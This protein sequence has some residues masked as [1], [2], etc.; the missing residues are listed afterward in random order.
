MDSLI[1]SSNFSTESLESITSPLVSS[2]ASIIQANVHSLLMSDDALE[3]LDLIFDI[4]D[5]AYAL[6]VLSEI[7]VNGF[8]LPDIQIVSEDIMAGALGGYAAE[9][10]NIYLSSALLSGDRIAGLI[11][12][13][14]EEVGHHLDTLLNGAYDSP[15]DEGELFRHHLWNDALSTSELSAIQRQDDHAQILVGGQSIQIEQNNSLGNAT[16]LG[17]LGRSVLRQGAIG[18]SDRNDYYRFS[19]TQSTAINLSLSNLSADADVQLLDSTGTVI[20]S[21][22]QG[23][24][25]EESILRRLAA[26][27]YF[28]RVYPFGNATTNYNL[29]ISVDGAGDSLTAAR[30]L[31]VFSGEGEFTDRIGD[32]DGND[33]Y[34]FTISQNSDFSLALDQLDADADV[35]LLNS[36]GQVITS[37]RRG[38]SNAESIR[39]TLAP[40][41][42]YARVYPFGT[43]ATDYR[44]QL[45]VDGAGNSLATAQNL[46]SISTLTTLNDF[47][48]QSDTND[49]YRF[50]LAQSRD[51]NLSL[52]NLAADADLQLLNSA[53]QVLASSVRSGSSSESISRSLAAGR[54]Y[55]RVY[56]FG[57]TTNT[58]YR[59]QLN[60]DG[61][62]NSLATARAVGQL[63]AGTT[64]FN[65]SVD[66]SD[67]NDFYRFSL[68][69][70][71]DLGVDLTGLS[72]DADLQFLDSAGAVITSSRRSGSSSEQLRLSL[73]AGTYYTRVYPFNGATTDYNLQF[74][75][76]QAGNSLTAA[77]NL[78]VLSGTQTFS[79][80][81][82]S[83]DQNDYYRFELSNSSNF[84]LSLN[85]LSEDADVQ[86]LNSAGQVITSSR[87]SN[88]N[89]ESIERFLNSGTYYVRVYPFNTAETNY[90]LALTADAAGNSLGDARNLGVFSGN[91]AFNDF[92]GASDSNDFYRF[93]LSQA[94]DFSLALSGLAADADV[95]LLNASGQ[96]ISSSTRGGTSSESLNQVLNQGTY[97][98]RVYPFA[99]SST[100]Y[101]LHLSSTALAPVDNAGNRLEVARNLGVLSGNRSFQDF[102]GSSDTNDFYR[103]EL[104]Q[105]SDFSLALTGL[106]ADADVQL[107]NSSGQVITGS[108]GSGSS[109][110]DLTRQL[111][112]GTYY[113][114]VYP[115][116]GST[117]YNLNLSATAVVRPDRAGNSLTSA[118][119]IGT[120]GSSQ[121]FQDFVGAI[122]T[123]DYYRFNLSQDSDFNLALTG[124][125]S[126][127]DVQ[128]LN[129][130]GELIQ[131]SYGERNLSESIEQR[132]NA[133]QYYIRVYPFSGNTDYELAVSATAI[134]PG[135]GAGNSRG[136]AR[137]IGILNGSRTF[138]DLVNLQDSDDYY[139]F[140]VRQTSN[141]SLSLAGLSADADVQLLNNSGQ[142][143]A[144]SIASSNSPESIYRE[145]TAGSY[146]VRVYSFLNANTNYRLRLN[147]TATTAGFNST[148]GYGLVNA[149]SAVASALGRSTPLAD[150]PNLTGNINWGLN[151]VN[152][153]EAWAGGHTGEGIVVAV[154]DSGVDINHSDL[155][156]NIWVNTGEIP[157]N[158]IDDDRNGYVDDVNGWN[159]GRNQNN[160]NVLPG[161]NDP[162]QGHGTHVAGTIAASNNGSGITGVAH[163]ASIMAI[164][165]GDVEGGRF[166]NAG[167]LARA[168]RY[169]V[170]NG[171][172]VI[173]MSLGWSDS[174]ELR[175]ALAYAASRNVITVSAAGN[176]G[177][178]SPGNPA[179][180]AT[181]YG[182]SVGA[183][184]SSGEIADFSNRAGN[185]SAL[186][187][188]V[189]PGVN[190]YSTEPNNRYGYSSGTSMAAP[191]VAGVIAL[192]LSAN[193][194]LTHAQVRQIL[195]NSTV[196]LS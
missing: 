156:D 95:Q 24:T 152:A 61:A 2:S 86:L 144:S 92:V 100:N 75:V 125:S 118:R 22:V 84:S 117:N 32:G 109:S 45:N 15:G 38:G 21:S 91:I 119:N 122:D 114:R 30:N 13:L 196:R 186:Q 7:E 184:D 12:V 182:I 140:E 52:S 174:A 1:S 85:G 132:L 103:F 106:T 81:V 162:G 194:N 133:G 87:L 190:V 4:Q 55:A 99:G 97:Y 39:R 63:A 170:D 161:T 93:Q 128:L 26:G 178:S 59:L 27:S 69:Q 189:A 104:N 180:Y 171:A 175:E 51:I 157:N 31:G 88:A 130:R 126:D 172:N 179:Q 191:H 62:G 80:A 120:L 70:A 25:A 192:M 142:V 28:V 71:S 129:S 107:L 67:P 73:D 153:P 82:D 115:Y 79:D 47:V 148:Y 195:V 177:E 44:L 72:A 110:E 18:G 11:G 158:G 111:T 42:Y 3:Q 146:Y 105:N 154:L 53:G 19:L 183:I 57:T 78:G 147:A 124:L 98:I 155:R 40:G 74:T 193:P 17:A 159:F 68:G 137:D 89:S 108:Y 60:P 43:A 20:T 49:F 165:L 160:N 188:V 163:D 58:S 121:S 185:N 166:T 173:N 139:R 168:I 176:S 135:D 101:R 10:Q 36:T 90:Q 181:Q 54:Y 37:S 5:R 102:V 167:S 33:Y 35:Q 77:R 187:H 34:R 138:R 9:N 56:P 127:A 23:G 143:I 145:L 66:S 50:D 131:G 116:A 96:V 29:R 16:N 41:T 113:L 76:D 136:T 123:N 151:T 169:A 65:D 8:T 6:G 14:T 64:T 94:S 134:V 46:G 112:A 141:F 83:S 149:A 164:R 48:G 150:V